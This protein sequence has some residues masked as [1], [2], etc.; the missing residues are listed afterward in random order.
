MTVKI[1]TL[2]NGIRVATD[3]MHT[4]ETVSMGVWVGVGSRYEKKPQSGIAHLLE[5]MMFKGTSKRSAQEI[6]E[7]IESVGGHINAYTSRENTAYYLKVLKED[8]DFALE[9]LSDA[10]LNSTFMN[11]ELKR[12]KSVVLQ[13]IGQSKDTP[14]D[15]IFDYFQSTAFPDQAVGRPILGNETTVNNTSRED[16]FNFVGEHYVTG[17]IVV[18]AAGHIN[19]DEFVKKVENAFQNVKAGHREKS[20]PSSYS[21]GIYKENKKLEQV[22]LLLGFPGVSIRNDD[23]YTSSVF[24][25]L[26][27]GGMSSRLFQEIRE[28][29]G[30]VYTI[31]SFS[32]SF[33]DGGIFGIYAGTSEKDIQELIPVTCDVLKTLPQSLSLKEIKRA[34]A[35]L[36]SSLLMS[37]ESTGTR[38]ELL[39]QQML[40]FNRHRPVDEIISN[41]EKVDENKIAQFA[42]NMLKLKPTICGLG[43]LS[44]MDDFETIQSY[45]H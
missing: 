17:N 4:V 40:I 21:G 8:T 29:R 34:K 45:L 7:E 25:A 19:H 20:E 26:L 13:E 24:S 12:E 15:I 6:A 10:F 36:K 32:S 5:H 16:L 18:S 31:Y 39:A 23:Y 38:C 42:E 1:T 22:H 14:D 2:A 33:S 37:R 30:L 27:G 9:I 28:K 41:I 3:A 11:E 43:P 44:K 35:Q